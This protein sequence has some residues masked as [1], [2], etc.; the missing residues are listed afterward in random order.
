MNG[1]L[2]SCPICHRG[3]CREWLEK[4]GYKHYWCGP[5]C[6]GFVHPV[7][8]EAVLRAYYSGLNS[9]MSSDCSWELAPAHKVSLWKGLLRRARALAGDG[10]LLDL[11]CGGGQFIQVAEGEGW[12]PVTGIEL[13]EK[14]A[15]LAEKATR[16]TILR[17]AW[18]EV[19]LPAEHYAVAALLD[20]LE[21]DRDPSALLQYIRRA[22]RP[23]GGLL[24]TLN[25]V[26]G[27]S[28]RWFGAE[29]EVVIPPEHLSHFSGRSL[30]RLLVREGFEVIWWSTR[31]VYLKEWL[32]YVPQARAGAEGAAGQRQGYLRWYRRLTGPVAL[33]GIRA[34]NVLLGLSGL[35]DELVCVA[36]KNEG[37]SSCKRAS[38]PTSYTSG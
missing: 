2:P 7:P 13:S 32:R 27:L 35:G 22:L 37:Q 16:A 38:Y 21:H 1:V 9:G 26:K 31:D 6:F 8:P 18:S 14:A 4:S 23:G 12:S 29:A 3:A 34:V 28:T 10:P 30:S 33:T 5:C 11:G 17:G 20:V 25:S 24:V 36:R 19:P 15:L